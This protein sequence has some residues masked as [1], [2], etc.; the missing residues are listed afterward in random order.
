MNSI[1]PAFIKHVYNK[2]GQEKGQQWLNL[3]PHRIDELVSRWN[4]TSIKPYDNL[5]HNYVAHAYRGGKPVVLKIGPSV[6][7]MNREAQALKYYAGNGCAALLD[8]DL[9]SG[10][11][12][13]EC[14]QPGTSLKQLFP[15][16]EKEA[17]KHAAIVMRQLHTKPLEPTHSFTTI[18]SWFDELAPQNNPAL[19]AHIKRAQPLAKHLL[20]TQKD[21]VLVHGDLHHENILKN[22]SNSW[23]AIDPKGVAGEAAFEVGCF[24]RNPIDQLSDH[25]NIKQ[26]VADRLDSFAQLLHIDRLR[27]QQWSYVQAVLAACWAYKNNKEL[28]QQFLIVADALQSQE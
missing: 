14:V 8:A 26:I 24:M 16:D 22:G 20:A 12:L 10:A 15:N 9:D 23:I 11:L 4:L 6:R 7:A 5:T 28:A 3:L 13:L 1:H 27:I 2:L 18:T 25:P 21:L 19:D 17:I